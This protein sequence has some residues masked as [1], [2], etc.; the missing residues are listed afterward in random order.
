MFDFG[1]TKPFKDYTIFM[2][3]LQKKKTYIIQ[4][5]IQNIFYC[6]YYL[7]ITKYQYLSDKT[8]LKIILLLCL[9]L[10]K[11]KTHFLYVSNPI[12]IFLLKNVE[13]RSEIKNIYMQNQTHSFTKIKLFCLS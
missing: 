13:I 2:L 4:K 12:C 1:G 3:I 7:K 9:L 6:F 10:R 5:Q 8:R 11:K